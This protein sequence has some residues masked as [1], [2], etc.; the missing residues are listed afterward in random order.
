MKPSES[1]GVSKGCGGRLWGPGFPQWSPHTPSSWFQRLI[2]PLGKCF[3]P[4]PRI[5]PLGTPQRGSGSQ[6]LPS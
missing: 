6:A 1:H 2:Q 4:D 5:G 3:H